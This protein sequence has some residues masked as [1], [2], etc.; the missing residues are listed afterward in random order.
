MTKQPQ[1][2][3]SHKAWGLIF[4]FNVASVLI[5][6][7]FFFPQWLPF[8]HKDVRGTVV[9]PASIA[10]VDGQITTAG[11]I[12]EA[13]KPVRF[14]VPAVNVD[15][16]VADGLYN[17]ATGNWTLSNDKA[18]YA[19]ITPYANNIEG[20]T[21]IYGHNRRA[22]FAPLLN[23]KAGDRAY[24]YTDNKKIFT[25]TLRSIKD[26]DPT[27][28]SLF[29]YQGKPILTVQTCSGTWY[30][31]RRLFTFDFVSVENQL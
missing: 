23:L 1:H 8:M 22:V 5:I 9:I 16:T 20:N 11:K 12:I 31:N 29:T 27:D 14:H 18:H 15:L 17:T 7:A 2:K 26:V 4:F 6:I 13:G 3:R 24:V 21:F 30:E 10:P 25:Y 19:T 28:V